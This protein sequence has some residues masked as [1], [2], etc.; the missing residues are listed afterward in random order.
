MAFPA[1]IIGQCFG[2]CD[3]TIA[4]RGIRTEARAQGYL[5][6]NGLGPNR[7]LTKSPVSAG[8]TELGGPFDFCGTGALDNYYQYSGSITQQA[9]PG[10]DPRYLGFVA[11]PTVEETVGS[12]GVITSSGSGGA[13]NVSVGTWLVDFNGTCGSCS[14]YYSAYTVYID[15]SVDFLDFSGSGVAPPPN[16]EPPPP[17]FPDRRIYETFSEVSHGLSGDG[18]YGTFELSNSDTLANVAGRLN[19]ARTSGHAYAGTGIVAGD[20]A[21]F[22][23]TNYPSLRYFNGQHGSYYEFHREWRDACE[24]DPGGEGAVGFDLDPD[25]FG[26]GL[27]M[28]TDD[29]FKSPYAVFETAVAWAKRHEHQAAMF[30]GCFSA[31]ARV[32]RTGWLKLKFDQVTVPLWASLQKVPACSGVPPPGSPEVAGGTTDTTGWTLELTESL[33]APVD[34]LGSMALDDDSWSGVS[35]KRRD[36]SSSPDVLAPAFQVAAFCRRHKVRLWSPVACTVTAQ[37][38][39]LNYKD[40]FDAGYPGLVST[41]TTT[42]TLTLTTAFD[43]GFYSAEWDDAPTNNCQEIWLRPT[44]VSAGDIADLRV[45]SKSRTGAPGFPQLDHAKDAIVWEGGKVFKG[46][47]KNTAW[48]EK[49]TFTYSHTAANT[50]ACQDSCVEIVG[51]DLDF[52]TEVIIEQEIDKTGDFTGGISEE[53]TVRAVCGQLWHYVSAESANGGTAIAAP[54]GE[55]YDH[56]PVWGCIGY[57][58]FTGTTASRVRTTTGTTRYIAALTASHL[59]IRHLF[60][61]E[62]YDQDY[63]SNFFLQNQAAPGDPE[64]HEGCPDGN[65]RCAVGAPL[66]NEEPYSASI[67]RAGGD[68]IDPFYGYSAAA[69]TASTTVTLDLDQAANGFYGE[70]LPELS[71]GVYDTAQLLTG[72]TSDANGRIYSPIA[73]SEIYT[74]AVPASGSYIVLRNVRL[75]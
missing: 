56:P 16:C 9:T 13:I 28:A 29:Y 15:G 48:Y 68:V 41:V 36:W 65:P 53:D 71:P 5:P 38:V 47:K 10:E 61:Q 11:V 64:E 46:Y 27:D 12:C 55:H 30:E 24:G 73:S 51:D 21:S 6:Y 34:S 59:P 25:V 70:E 75:G 37:R 7:Y 18:N 57:D 1:S 2:C 19:S 62:R 32:G 67:H 35:L 50:G 44:A 72:E 31:Y 54:T 14:A 40:A 23:D 52:A 8:W 3:F 63:W 22:Q 45:F 33:T 66:C 42:V 26:H 39:E 20:Y 17:G 49:Q 69:Q 58:T 43:G 4:V 74:V 60:G